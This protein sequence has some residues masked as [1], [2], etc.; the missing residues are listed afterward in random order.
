MNDVDFTIEGSE[1][2]EVKK[3]DQELRSDKT[4]MST[5]RHDPKP[6]LRTTALLEYRT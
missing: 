2:K 1:A 4:R 5:K 3:L 6:M